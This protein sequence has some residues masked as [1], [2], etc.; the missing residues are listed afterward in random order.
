MAT[1]LRPALERAGYR[2]ATVLKP[3]E[4]A[5]LTLAMDDDAVTDDAPVLRLSRERRDGADAVF[6]YDRAGLAEALARHAAGA[7]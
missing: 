1:F 6:R 3:G 7:R 5:A 2:V 4:S